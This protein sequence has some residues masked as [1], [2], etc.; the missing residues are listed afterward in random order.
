MSTSACLHSMV[1]CLV[2][3]CSPYSDTAISFILD[4]S[5]SHDVGQALPSDL[6]AV[7]GLSIKIYLESSSASPEILLDGL[8]LPLN[9]SGFEAQVNITK[10]PPSSRPYN[11]TCV[12]NLN[13]QDGSSNYSTFTV[14]SDAQ[15]YRLPENPYEGSV[16]KMDWRTGGM[17]RR[18]EDSGLWRP[19]LPFGFYTYTDNL[20]ANLSMIDAM[21]ADGCGVIYIYVARLFSRRS[22]FN[23][24]HLVPTFEANQNWDALA[25]VLDRADAM[26]VGS[27]DT[28]N[29]MEPDRFH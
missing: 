26:G 21:S 11:V 25:S 4:A 27:D 3:S 13:F 23:V 7:E 28:G 22:R 14:T 15:L 5:I 17:V 20:V 8:K 10:F 12:A 2:I 1:L 29:R 16:T 19:F 24:I 9:T 18:E 6:A